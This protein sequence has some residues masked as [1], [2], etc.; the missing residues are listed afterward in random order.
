[1][2]KQSSCWALITDSLSARSYSITGVLAGQL[3]RAYVH[4]QCTWGAFI[5]ASL[6]VHTCIT[7]VPGD[8]YCC[9]LEGAYMHNQCTCWAFI[10]ASLSVHTCITSVPGGLYCCQLEGATCITSAFI[11]FIAAS[12]SVHTCITSVPAGPL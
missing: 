2:H 3:E 6:S 10:A 1:M 5:A 7:S 9:Q 12:L 11:Q 4:N 8:L